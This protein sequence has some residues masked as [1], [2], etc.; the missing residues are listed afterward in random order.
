GGDEREVTAR[1]RPTGRVGRRPGT[2]RERRAR[3]ACPRRLADRPAH[4]GRRDRLGDPPAVPHHPVAPARAGLL[5][6]AGGAAD[7]GR[8]GGDPVP[9]L[10]RQAARRRPR[11]SR[12]G[13]VN[14]PAEVVHWMFASGVLFLGLLKLAEAIAGPAVW[15]RRKWRIYL[16][17]GLLFALGVWMWPVMTFYTNSA[18]HM[19][20]PSAWAP[21]PMLLRAA[22][23]RPA[24]RQPPRHPGRPPP[25]PS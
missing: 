16:W 24:P 22:E 21:A 3:R 8:R 2:R 20:A 25:P 23:L 19:L 17:P 18:G 12:G 11:G 5:V 1:R 10:R 13:R 15:R 7:L 4:G 6:P 9:A 14:P